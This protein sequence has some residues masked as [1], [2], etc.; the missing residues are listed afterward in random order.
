MQRPA[1]ST[2]P[3]TTLSRFTH[4]DNQFLAQ[5]GQGGFDLLN[6]TCMSEA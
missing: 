4:A 1:L 6:A 5:S 3:E 2:H